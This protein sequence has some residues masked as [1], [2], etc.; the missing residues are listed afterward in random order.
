MAF[1]RFVTGSWRSSLKTSFSITMRPFFWRLVSLPITILTLFFVPGEGF[2]QVP[3]TPDYQQIE[4]EVD[5]GT[6]G[7]EAAEK[8]QQE[9]AGKNKYR[10]GSDDDPEQNMQKLFDKILKTDGSADQWYS[11]HLRD[12]Q[13]PEGDRGLVLPYRSE[14]GAALIIPLFFCRLCINGLGGLQTACPICQPQNGGCPGQAWKDKH[15]EE[16]QPPDVCCFKNTAFYQ[17][18]YQDSNFKTCCVRKAEKERPTEE[19]ACK[20][21]MGDGWAGLFEYYYPTEALGWEND[22]TTTMLASK[23]EVQKCLQQSDPLMEQRAGS[24]V[25][26]A[27]QKNLEVA[28]KL[29]G[30]GGSAGGD[31]TSQIQQD[32]QAVRPQDKELRFA[33]SLQG[34][35]LTMRVNFPAMKDDFR[36]KL[37]KHFCMHPDQFMKLMDHDP[38]EDPLQKEYSDFKSM[39]IWS[40]YCKEGVQLMTDPDETGKCKNIDNT[41]TDLPKGLEAWKQD[42][43]YCQRM[44]LS[45]SKMQEFFG[46]VLEKSGGGAQSEAAVG[47]T[48]RDG[49]KLNGSL[50][51]VEMYRHAAVERRTTIAD[52]ALGF[53][54]A[55]GLYEGEMRK[56]RKSLYKR[57][58]PRPYSLLWEIFTGKQFKGSGSGPF[59]ER[60]FVDAANSFCESVNGE[61]LT[62]Q[63]RSDRL[64]ISD[65][66]HKNVFTDEKINAPEGK[67]FNRYVQEWAKPAGEKKITNRGLDEKSSNYAAPFRIFATCPKGYTR[68]NPNDTHMPA[69]AKV[70]NA[71]DLGGLQLLP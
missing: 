19:I 47:Y 65:Y 34:E 71:E 21:P 3:R 5:S 58:E 70:C 54:I 39:P 12:A 48:C 13:Y 20:H 41:P 27:I 55:G 60:V 61:M 11:P 18:F 9:K 17:L 1:M 15:W 2:A 38:S 7:K 33:D 28:N 26:K 67:E 43:L 62:G 31:L 42:P 69:I 49:G 57:F 29:G 51:P 40:N 56:D 46:G 64:Y 14:A 10:G 6:K 35:G 30:G 68:W 25:N 45:N 53:L 52:S 23:Q 50:V 44:N 59:N 16:L 66:T 36:R 32:A 37:A 8:L 22:R 63:N 24:W 4:S